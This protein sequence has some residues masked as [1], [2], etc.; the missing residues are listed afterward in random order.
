MSLNIKRVFYSPIDGKLHGAQF[1]DGI[2]V[3]DG[4]DKDDPY[5]IYPLHVRRRR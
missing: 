5:W 4:K 1:I 2:L 3:N